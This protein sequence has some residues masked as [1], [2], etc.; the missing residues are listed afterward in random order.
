[1]SQLLARERRAQIETP[2]VMI[3]AVVAG[4][5]VLLVV[6]WFLVQQQSGA[7]NERS[8]THLKGVSDAIESA[9]ST[10]NA[11]QN[12]TLIDELRLECS[13]T[14]LELWYGTR[15]TQPVPGIIVFGQSSVKGIATIRSAPIGGAFR[16]GNAVYVTAPQ[17][18]PSTVLT[19]NDE[20]REYPGAGTV[21]FGPRA[22]PYFSPALLEGAK[23]SGNADIYACGL[24]ETLK[25]YRFANLIQWERTRMLMEEYLDRDSSCAYLYDETPFITINDAVR[26]PNDKTKDARTAQFTLQ[27]A[28]AIIQA[29][30]QIEQMNNNLVRASCVTVS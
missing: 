24:T 12:V 3:F 16:I 15:D 28:E 17:M 20:S 21:S 5:M 1:M 18:T 11:K 14:G 26:L 10:L 2:V 9:G 25:R 29:E 4:V 7:T 19:D 8:L 6:G 22:I 30:R 23:V 27:D 13:E